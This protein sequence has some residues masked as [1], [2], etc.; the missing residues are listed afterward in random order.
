MTSFAS[1]RR[2]TS[3]TL[4]FSTR[5]ES[6][7]FL[8]SS[9]TSLQWFPRPDGIFAYKERFYAPSGASGWCYGA[10]VA[11]RWRRE[12]R[13]PVVEKDVWSVVEEDGLSECG[14]WWVEEMWI[15]WWV[16]EEVFR[17]TG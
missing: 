6:V 2:D 16:E 17:R 10:A 13:S 11:L 1:S 3:L 4:A 5:R 15:A 8:L 14:A 7:S 9:P 12:P